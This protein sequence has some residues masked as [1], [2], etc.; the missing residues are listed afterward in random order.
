M[1]ASLLLK[2]FLSVGLTA[3]GLM[4][5]MNPEIAAAEQRSLSLF[6]PVTEPIIALYEVA[7]IPAIFY[8]STAV[9]NAYLGF[10]C[11]C[12]VIISLIYLRNH[13]LAEIPQLVAFTDDL[14]VIW[15]H[16]LIAVLMTTLI[17]I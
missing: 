15:Y 14:K 9:R 13:R 5:L 16:I 4:R 11:A 2:I 3:A 1:E 10:Y 12:V 6:N 17:L 8:A 7:A